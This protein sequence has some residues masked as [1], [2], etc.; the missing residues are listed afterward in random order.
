MQFDPGEQRTVQVP[1][2][3][4]KE[5]TVQVPKIIME[6]E[7]RT[8]QVPKTIMKKEEITVHGVSKVIEVPKVVLEEQE[9]TVQVPKTVME[10]QQVTVQEPVMESVEI[11]VIPPKVPQPCPPLSLV[12][13]RTLHSALSNATAITVWDTD[14]RFLIADIGTWRACRDPLNAGAG[15]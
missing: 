14:E 6:Q 5:I 10:D 9:I 4:V 15:L 11:T 8:V 12:A 13:L 2:M 7:K 3:I 1:K